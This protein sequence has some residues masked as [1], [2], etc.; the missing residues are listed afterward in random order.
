[1]AIETIAIRINSPVF[2]RGVL[3]PFPASMIQAYDVI[4]VNHAYLRFAYHSISAPDEP[5]V[6]AVST[7]FI[8]FDLSKLLILTVALLLPRGKLL[9]SISGETWIRTMTRS[10]FA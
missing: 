2:I 8:H 6:L 5:D 3:F 7:C 10:G 1:M 9:L 4:P